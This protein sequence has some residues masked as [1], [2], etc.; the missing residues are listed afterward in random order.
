MSLLSPK[1]SCLGVARPFKRP[2]VLHSTPAEYYGKKAVFLYGFTPSL[3]SVEFT[4]KKRQSQ[5][6]NSADPKR[7]AS[8]C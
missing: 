3:L 8:C 1:L 6:H 2:G 5:E 7:I 4:L